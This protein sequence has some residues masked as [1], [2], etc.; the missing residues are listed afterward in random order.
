MIDSL[1]L[2]V[3]HNTTRQI[4]N[5]ADVPDKRAEKDQPYIRKANFLFDKKHRRSGKSLN[6]FVYYGHKHPI[7]RESQHYKV[8]FVETHSMTAAQ[9]QDQLHE[10]FVLS[11]L[12]IRRLKTMRVD[13]AL[14]VPWVPIQWFRE[15]CYIPFK[16]H[17]DGVR[18]TESIIRGYTTL[19]IGKRPDFYKIYDKVK[20]I[21]HH[22][23]SSPFM[24]AI[25]G[26][27]ELTLSRIERQCSGVGIPIHLR[28]FGGLLEGAAEFK[29]FGL[30]RFRK[31]AAKPD[32]E[33]WKAN[34]WLKCMGLKAAVDDLGEIAVRKRLNRDGLNK[35]S[36]YFTRYSD[37]LCPMGEQLTTEMLQEHYRLSTIC[38]LNPPQT[39]IRPKRV[40]V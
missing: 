40:S 16:Q 34:K 39:G 38:Q 7:R 27:P 17:S 25:S 28:T 18:S 26:E 24:G 8:Q 10:L 33:K 3:P 11:D 30:L 20:E 21:K 15:N 23:K 19:V 35:A 31:N 9:L 4:R 29:P 32:S 1:E 6:V 2:S 12:E 22:K 13:F 5:W 36:H 14:D 37:L